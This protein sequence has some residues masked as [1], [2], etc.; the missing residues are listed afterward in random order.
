MLINGWHSDKTQERYLHIVIPMGVTVIAMIIAVSTLNTAGRY[1]AM[2]LMP[3]SFYAAGIII[4]SWIA[5]SIPQPK[6]KRAIAIS[7]INAVCNT[8]NVS[9]SRS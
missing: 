9:F 7:L 1:I 5:G 3:T 8:P 2:C 6:V 4:L